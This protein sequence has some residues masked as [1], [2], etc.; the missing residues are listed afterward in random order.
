MERQHDGV[1]ATGRFKCKICGETQE[2][3][4][5]LDV[6]EGDRFV[7]EKVQALNKV[8]PGAFWLRATTHAHTHTRTHARQR[9]SKRVWRVATRIVGGAERRHEHRRPA[10]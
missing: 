5:I 7:R 6:V 2:I 9:C 10:K 3:G 4:A 1:A 8:R